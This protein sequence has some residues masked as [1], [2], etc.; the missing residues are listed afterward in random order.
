MA[1][2][3]DITVFQEVSPRFAEIAA[4]STEIVMQDYVDTLRGL[5]DDFLNMSFPFLIQASGKEDLGGGVLVAITVEEQNLQLA[6]EPRFAP[7]VTGTVTTASGPPNINNRITFADSAADFVT[8]GV[9]PGS[10]LINW[11]D[12]SVTDVV[13][14]IDANTLETRVLNNGTDNE[15]DLADDYSLWNITQVRT[16]G[17]NLVAVDDL[18]AAISAIL[19]TWG[20][21]VILSTSSSATIQELTEIRYAAYGGGVS[22][23]P[24]HPNAT[25]GTDYPA[26]TMAAPSDNWADALTIHDNLGLK[27][28][29]LNNTSYTVPASTDLSNDVWIIG[30]G[31]TVTTLLIPDSANTANLRI[32][33][34]YLDQSVIDDANLVE[35]CVL[36]D[37][38][39]SGGFYFEN[40]FSGTTIITGSGQCNIYECYSAVAGGGAG[41]TPTFNVGTAIIA[42]RGWTGGVEFT[43]KSSAAAFSWDME[44]GRVIV[45]DN[46]TAGTM[47]FRGTG[48]W[49]NADTYAGTTV[50]QDQ[51][52]NTANNAAAVWDS[53]IADHSVTGSFG[54]FI[55]RRLLTTA[56]F[57][58]LR[59]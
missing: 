48:E 39:I 51:M 58:S 56:R 9:Q 22:L 32:Q 49:E 8:A 44:S 4:P 37:C 52:H 46:N 11:T 15:W 12:R 35:R 2:R 57:F 42:G 27:K 40:A 6:F 21:Q 13:R 59:N 30:A 19:P 50:V 36:D 54:E 31:A 47:T 18:D 33:D 41:Q 5:E 1:T 28:I 3:D 20:T 10:Y 24:T 14:V 38:S 16:S 43:L 25:S 23:D 34:C 7:A 45:N 55:V 53:L 29:F 17:G 26:G